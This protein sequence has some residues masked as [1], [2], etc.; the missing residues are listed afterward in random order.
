MYLLV[1]SLLQGI[2]INYSSIRILAKQLYKVIQN[3]VLSNKINIRPV[4]RYISIG[5]AMKRTYSI[6]MLYQV[7]IRYH[8]MTRFEQIRLN[9]R[10]CTNCMSRSP[11][12]W[13]M[14]QQ[15]RMSPVLRRGTSWTL[16][17]YLG[18]GQLHSW[19]PVDHLSGYT[20]NLTY[21]YT[22]TMVEVSYINK[23]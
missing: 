13:N 19:S 14:I 15:G 17:R 11:H 12:R 7:C 22:Q 2:V 20:R 8:P 4:D 21:I 16:Q 3:L 5:Y 23:Y 18:I 6:A 9:W 10:H 1:D